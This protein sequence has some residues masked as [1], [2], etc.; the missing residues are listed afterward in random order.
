MLI[1]VL[2]FL[3]GVIAGLRALT[4]PTVVSW[5]AYLG[6]INLADTSLSWLGNIVTAI[7]L[8]ILALGEIVNDKRPA[9]P[10]R[11]ILPQFITRLVTGGFSAGALGLSNGTLFSGLL[12]GVIGAACGT[13]GGAKFRAALSKAFGQDLP[14]ALIEDV[15]AVGGG[16]LIVSMAH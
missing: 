11:L 7:I 9:T 10:S 13:I 1:V 2:A 6:W 8:T 15:I 16:L 5:A 14:A 4:A 3:I 12:A